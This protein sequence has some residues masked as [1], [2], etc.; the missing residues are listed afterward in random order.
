MV[1]QLSIPTVSVI[2]TVYNRADYLD[3]SIGSLLSQS[4]KDWE[5]IAIDDGSDDDS[6]EILKEY[7]WEN[8]NIKIIRQSNMKLPLSRNTGILASTGKYITFLD[9]DDEYKTDHLLNRVNF[10]NNHPG[11]DLIRGT[12]D[13]VGNEYVRDKEDLKRFIHLSECK[14]G[15]TFFGRRDVFLT[16]KGFKNI[17]YSEDS[18]F[19]ERAEKLFNTTKVPFN[20]YIYHR[21]DPDSITNKISRN[22]ERMSDK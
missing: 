11:I 19:W 3:R 6:Y 20:T 16:L 9:S 12:V 13:I 21:D 17:E 15:A 22:L 18:D 14:I 4:F 10:M 7:L 2:L 1:N 5:L 8:K